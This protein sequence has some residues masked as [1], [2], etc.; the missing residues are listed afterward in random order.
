MLERVPRLH[1]VKEHLQQT[2]ADTLTEH[3]RYIVEP[4]DDPPEIRDWVWGAA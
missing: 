3:R 2:I 1:D 4:G